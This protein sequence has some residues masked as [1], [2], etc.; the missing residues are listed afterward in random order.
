MF[1]VVHN[2]ISDL[3]EVHV[4]DHVVVLCA[5]KEYYRISCDYR[6]NSARARSCNCNWKLIHPDDKL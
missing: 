5:L 3:I 4:G 1:G 6:I 2:Q